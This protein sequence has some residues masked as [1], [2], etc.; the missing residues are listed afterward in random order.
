MN[1]L[2]LFRVRVE[3]IYWAGKASLSGKG[4]DGV[5]KIQVVAAPLLTVSDRGQQYQLIKSW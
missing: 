5:V 2:Q 4:N 1:M 3:N